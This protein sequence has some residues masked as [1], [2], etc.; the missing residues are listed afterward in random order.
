[1]KDQVQQIAER[2]FFGSIKGTIEFVPDIV[3]PLDIHWEAETD[4][5]IPEV[6]GLLHDAAGAQ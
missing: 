2:L 3:S 1:M 4:W 5:Q 6:G